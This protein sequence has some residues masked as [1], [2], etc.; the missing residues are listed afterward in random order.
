MTDEA[1]TQ[2]LYDLLNYKLREHEVRRLLGL[3]A[4]YEVRLVPGLTA[5]YRWAGVE[6]RVHPRGDDAVVQ[7]HDEVSFGRWLARRGHPF[8]R[9]FEAATTLVR[10]APSVAWAALAWWR[11]RN[12]TFTEALAAVRRDAATAADFGHVELARQRWSP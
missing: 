1:A 3:L 12:L 6:A 5:P 7:V 10:L 9:V 8:A 2:A 11:A 4:G